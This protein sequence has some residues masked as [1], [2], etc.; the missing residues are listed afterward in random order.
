MQ[1]T[2][3]APK[4]KSH[5]YGQ[6]ETIIVMMGTVPSKSLIQCGTADS[7]GSEPKGRIIQYVIITT[8]KGAAPT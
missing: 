6:G 8:H 3:P 4:V 1:E 5:A 7:A 2:L